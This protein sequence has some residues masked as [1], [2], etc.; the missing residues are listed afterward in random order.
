M[1]DTLDDLPVFAGD[2]VEGPRTPIPASPA[3]AA[4]LA[5]N[6]E[7]RLTGP[8]RRLLLS[9]GVGA[10][11]FLLCPSALLI[12]MIAAVLSG[13][14]PFPTLGGAIFTVIGVGFLL[15]LAGLLGTNAIAFLGD[16]LA[17]RPV[18][19]ARGP[20]QIRL[21]AGNRPELPFSY[22]VG[23]Y[24]FA[25]YVPPYDLPMRTDAPYIVYYAA[26]TRLLLSMAALDAPDGSQWEPVSGGD[27]QG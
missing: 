10:L 23:G 16:G 6:R 14:A 1:T 26:R 22:S 13:A 11:L 24:S 27:R 20:L 25:P 9:V 2:E 5:V 15:V 19:Y 4:R 18:R 17:R 3:M 7:G 8:Q 12:Q 21:T